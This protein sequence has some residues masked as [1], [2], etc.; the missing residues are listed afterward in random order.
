[1][2]EFIIAIVA[3][4]LASSGL[5]SFIL[6]KVQKHDEKKDSLTRLILGLAYRE[7][8][9][10]C[11]MYIQRGYITKDE[12]EDLIKY[13]FSPYK[14]LGG[15]GTAEKLI[16]EIQFPKELIINYNEEQILEFFNIK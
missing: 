7:I 4:T 15:D 12:Y 16:E 5:W 2:T 14:E 1:M 3:A 9:E 8:T 6:Y 13:L 10:L 11:I